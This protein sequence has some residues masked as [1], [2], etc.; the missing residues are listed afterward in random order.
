MNLKLPQVIGHRGA[1]AAAPENTLES[2]RQAAAEGARW[3]EFDAK[4]SAEGRV[5]LLHDDDLDR[6]TNGKGAARLKTLSELKQLDAGGWYNPRFAGAKLP[7]LAETVTLLNELDLQCNVEIKPCP[8]RDVETAE[9]IMAELRKIWPADKEKPLISSF[10]LDSLRTV[11]AA[12]PEFPRGILFDGHPIDWLSQARGVAAISVNI[13]NDDA[14]PQWV[15]EIKQAGYGVLVYTINDPERA[16]Q[17]IGW[18]VDGVFSDAPGR[19]LARLAKG[20]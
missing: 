4:L 9:V 16:A 19:I 17:L 5:F 1:A 8:G 3:V 11:Q 14:T 20:L 6:T 13:G 18:G 12:A 10:V 15:E 7:T 2:F